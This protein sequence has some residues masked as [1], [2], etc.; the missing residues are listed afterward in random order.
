MAV[1]GVGL[2]AW[3][4][5]AVGLGLGCNRCGEYE[6]RLVSRWTTLGARA[7]RVTDSLWLGEQA[8]LGAIAV[9]NAGHVVSCFSRSVG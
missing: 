1:V 5:L 3:V 4:G 8:I 9:A 2:S 6:W 7:R